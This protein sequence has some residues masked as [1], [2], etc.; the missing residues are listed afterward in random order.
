[1]SGPD[2]PAL[3][4]LFRLGR[5]TRR[6]FVSGL[7]ASGLTVSAIELLAGC[8]SIPVPEAKVVARSL[9]L[10]VLDAF[11]PDYAALAPMPALQTL[12]ARGTTFERAWVGQLETQTPPAH[13]T[14]STGLF[15]RND[16]ILGFEW[17]DP[18]TRR[19]V[20]AGWE[21]GS[22]LGALG[23]RME[24][25]RP[26]SIPWSIKA[27][28]PNAT[29]VTISSEKVYAADTLAAHAADYVLFH[30]FAGGRLQATALPGQ[31]P[32]RDFFAD[33]SLDLT[34]PLRRFTDWDTLS[35]DLAVAAFAAFHPRA[36]MV[37]LPGTD[38]YGHAYGGP[39]SPEI[40]AKVVRG[41]DRAI[42]R[43]VDL[44]RRAGT[45]DETLFVVTADH[46]LVSNHH[47]V[48]PAMVRSAVARAEAEYLFHTGGSAKYIYL[49][50]PSP[51]A[52]RAVAREM[53]RLPGV[54]AAYFQTGAGFEPVPT[55]IDG[56][57]QAAHGYLLG[58][59]RGPI[60]PDVVAVYR[61]STVGTALP[62][63]YG[64]HG[65]LSWKVQHV[66][67]VLAGPGIRPG[68]RSRTPAR[69]VDIAPTIHRAM[70]L[71]PPPMDGL[72]LAGA[73]RNAT[74]LEVHAQAASLNRLER[75]QDAL[76]E[77]S[78]AD[79][80]EDRRNSMGPPPAR[81]PVP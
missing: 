7:A 45:V 48:T 58:T 22:S 3:E 71:S 19:E 56:D 27:A 62:W 4:R 49:R 69:L 8:G 80:R 81:A 79:L 5:L 72:V 23:R 63:A 24:A 11:R 53:L 33:R 26:Q 51:T 9:C 57:V 41:Q 13:A 40:M 65:G 77:Q 36:L 34:L 54:V 64:N 30:R 43:I 50:R 2:P 68:I 66:P 70:G 10:I 61:E 6:Q 31:A 74:A 75:H 12:I 78:D 73:I 59:F 32:P 60:A 37:N 29:V 25:T 28:D 1:M 17:R 42:A 76:R 38:V 14:I 47:V 67:L 39:A 21:Q 55:A 52:A 18:E 15:P 35:A 20:L 16:G 44:Y 46:G